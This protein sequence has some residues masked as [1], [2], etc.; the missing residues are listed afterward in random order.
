MA[1]AV[2]TEAVLRI[3]VLDI[4][5]N[6]NIPPTGRLTLDHLEQEWKETGLRLDDLVRGTQSLI[7]DGYMAL[8]TVEGER[9]LQLTQEGYDHMTTP[10]TPAGIRDRMRASRV[11]HQ[12][13]R[14]L[15]NDADAAEAALQQGE[16]EGLTRRLRAIPDAH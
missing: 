6:L 2:I 10:T 14:R 7:A 11:I 9:C 15:K 16:E 1:D 5:N 12:A 4:F 13:Q 8:Q 3:A